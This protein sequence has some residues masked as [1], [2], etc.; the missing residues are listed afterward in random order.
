MFGSTVKDIEDTPDTESVFH[1]L[2][3]DTAVR[4]GVRSASGCRRRPPYPPGAGDLGRVAGI[5]A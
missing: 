4:G 1:D 3:P 2:L 5:L